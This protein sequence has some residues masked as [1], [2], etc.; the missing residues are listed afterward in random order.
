MILNFILCCTAVQGYPVRLYFCSP[1]LQLC[2]TQGR[3]HKWSQHLWFTKCSLLKAKGECW[4][5]ALLL[6]L[7]TMTGWPWSWVWRA[8]KHLSDKAAQVKTYGNISSS[9][10]DKVDSCWCSMWLTFYKDLLNSICSLCCMCWLS[11]IG[12]NLTCLLLQ[13]PTIFHILLK[14]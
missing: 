6:I 8:S 7:A 10:I 5:V 14:M 12:S 4:P 3:Q 9:P 13:L 1:V 11:S 2:M